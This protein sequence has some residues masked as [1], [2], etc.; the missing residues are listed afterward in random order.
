MVHDDS[1]RPIFLFSLR[2]WGIDVNDQRLM[3]EEAV[4]ELL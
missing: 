3:T 4:W 1:W 2:E